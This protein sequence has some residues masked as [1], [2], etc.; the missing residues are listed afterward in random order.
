MEADDNTPA[1]LPPWVLL[2]YTHI[3]TRTYSSASPNNTVYFTNLSPKSAS[4]LTS[5]LSSSSSSSEGRSKFVATAKSVMDLIEEGTLPSK[6]KICLLD[7]RAE[8][9]IGK[10]D[11]EEF[12]AFL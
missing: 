5:Q 2:E 12:D 11:R 4:A 6:E 1:S 3:L 8:K 7:P 10:G 9:V